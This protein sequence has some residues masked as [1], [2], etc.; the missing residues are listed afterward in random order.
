M[1]LA[2]EVRPGTR[3]GWPL[4]ICRPT[5]GLTAGLGLF[6]LFSK[7]QLFP[8]FLFWQPLLK[9]SPSACV[10]APA[11]EAAPGLG[12]GRLGPSRDILSWPQPQGHGHQLPL[13]PA[14]SHP[15][16]SAELSA[17]S[18]G[19]Y[20]H[21]D[22]WMHKHMDVWI[23][24]HGHTDVWTHGCSD[25]QAHGV[26]VAQVYGCMDIRT[27]GYTD[28]GMYGCTDARTHGYTDT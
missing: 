27:H 25:T 9:N 16:R 15:A 11:G 5:P 22:A 20:G 14:W 23:Q 1:V 26:T 21:T 3:M 2:A 6:R 7:N 13:P 19:R 12:S 24:A 4:G 28:A 18:E 17:P 10:P 8:P